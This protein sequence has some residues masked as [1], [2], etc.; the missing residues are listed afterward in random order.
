MKNKEAFLE[1][2]IVTMLDA[3]MAKGGGHMNV[4]VNDIQTNPVKQVKETKSSECNSK[5][6]ACQVPTFILQEE[7]EQE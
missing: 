7:L 6:M 5:Q 2:D 1:E 3:F 4:D